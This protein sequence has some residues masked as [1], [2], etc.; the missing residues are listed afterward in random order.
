M[1]HADPHCQVIPEDGIISLDNGVYKIWF[2]RQFETLQSNTLLL[3]NALATMGA[4]LPCAI[5]AKLVHPEKVVV[6]VCG[7]GGFMMNS[8]EIETALRCN[9]PISPSPLYDPPFPLGSKG[10]RSLSGVSAHQRNAPRTKDS[11][12][13]QP[14]EPAPGELHLT[15]HNPRAIRLL[16]P[17]LP[18]YFGK[19]VHTCL[20]HLF[21]FHSFLSQTTGRSTDK[22]ST[23]Y[24]ELL[25]RC[26]SL[27]LAAFKPEA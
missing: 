22:P 23:L 26:F 1:V 8:Q 7:D 13:V 4:G 16:S 3:D 25:N 11:C 21:L 12:R 19:E 18:P 24:E 14:W 15:A 9:L 5:A 6:A 17:L 2:A 27:P 10:G 20:W